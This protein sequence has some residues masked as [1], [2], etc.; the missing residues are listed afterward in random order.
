MRNW[1]FS[2]LV[3][4]SASMV[5]GCYYVDADIGS[6]ELDKGLPIKTDWSTTGSFTAMRATGPDNII[7]QTDDAF[8]IKATGDADVVKELRFI[9]KDGRILIGRKSGSSY[10]T[11]DAATITVTAPAL[12]G[13]SLAGSGNISA[14]RLSGNEAK[15]SVAGS[16]NADVAILDAESLTAKIAG[17]GRLKLAGKVPVADYS[18]A[19]SGGLDA[20]GLESSAVKISIA[21][22]GDAI[23][24]STNSVA[25]KI[26]GSG[27]V[28]VSGGAKCTSK[29]AGSG[30]LDC[31]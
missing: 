25:A 17:S 27:N 3:V 24:R 20:G 10:G 14:D 6:H 23:L 21:G 22:S 31:K 29:V 1:F 30:S 5:S 18:I 9:V 13:I 26:A 12:S 8:Q 15:L 4:M 16:G 11:K 2:A 7:F 28:K 19:G